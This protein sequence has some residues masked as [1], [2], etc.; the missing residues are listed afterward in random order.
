ML[1][2]GV[3]FISTF[4][5]RSWE[6]VICLR[7]LKIDHFE[8]EISK[9]DAA[10]LVKGLGTWSAQIALGLFSRQIERNIFTVK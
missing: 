8:Q 5:N 4:C 7:S 9:G 3:F 6:A 1:A 10:V 2:Y